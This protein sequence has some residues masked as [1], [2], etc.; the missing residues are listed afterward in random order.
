MEQSVL[1]WPTSLTFSLSTAYHSTAEAC[2]KGTFAASISANRD[3]QARSSLGVHVAVTGSLR[4]SNASS[5]SLARFEFLKE[6]NAQLLAHF[7]LDFTNPLPKD[8]TNSANIAI[9]EAGATG[10]P[11]T[12][13]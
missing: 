9:T 4:S 10:E 5:A 7:M 1:T 11:L 6:T 8:K 2:I 13:Q 3:P 12:G